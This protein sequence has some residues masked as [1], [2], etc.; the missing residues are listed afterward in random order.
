MESRIIRLEERVETLL[1]QAMAHRPKTSSP[2]DYQPS[3][4]AF[5]KSP[6]KPLQSIPLTSIPPNAINRNFT[7]R[8]SLAKTPPSRAL[9]TMPIQSVQPVKPVVTRA[10]Q[11]HDELDDIYFELSASQSHSS[12]ELCSSS[13]QPSSSSS[14]SSSSSHGTPGSSFLQSHA[15]T[16]PP[17]RLRL[18]AKLGAEERRR[19]LDSNTWLNDNIIDYWI[20]VIARKNPNP[21]Y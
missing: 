18:S 13:T 20:E 11:Q 10:M 12:S 14:S 21:I 19:L 5:L 6:T 7:H 1:V 9:S 4:P 15:A 16:A 17:K 3:P 8:E 2:G